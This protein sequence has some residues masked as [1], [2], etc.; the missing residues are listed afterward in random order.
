M[1]KRLVPVRQVVA[2]SGAVEHQQLVDLASKAFS[3]LPSTPTT[4]ADL[5][6]K[7]LAWTCL[8]VLL[9]LLVPEVWGFVVTSCLFFTCA[10][11]RYVLHELGT[12]EILP[13]LLLFP[14]SS[15]VRFI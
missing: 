7:V 13:C 11:V 5:V 8:P 14:P 3:S 4:A 6:E 12:P 15:G 1:R 10:L 9:V 2:G